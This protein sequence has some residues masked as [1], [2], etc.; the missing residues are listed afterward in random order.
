MTSTPNYFYLDGQ[1]LVAVDNGDSTKTLAVSASTLPLPTGAATE[2]T[3][4]ALNTK[5]PAQILAGLLP[6][7]VLGTPTR[8][9][10]QTLTGTSQSVALLSTTRRVSVDVSVN[11]IVRLN[12]TASVPANGSSLTDA[13]AI[14]VGTKDFDVPA[15]CTLHF[16][17]DGSVDGTIRI[18]EIV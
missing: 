17:R 9:T 6:V 18:S 2:T 3:L 16:I 5:I 13:I 1:K 4:A 10:P 12:A 8:V 15:N 14:P 7:D 11:A